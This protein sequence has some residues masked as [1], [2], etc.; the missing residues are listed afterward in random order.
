[1]AQ[2]ASSASSTTSAAL[3]RKST[4]LQRLRR[5]LEELQRCPLVGVAAQPLEENLQE[6]H[7]NMAP[8]KG[9][10][11]GLLLHLVLKFPDD[12][13]SNPPKV[14]LCTQIPHSNVIPNLRGERNFICIDMLKN[15]FWMGGEDDSRPYEG[16]STAYSVSSILLQIQCF[17]FDDWA[18]NYDGR[19]KN[20][21]WDAVIEEGGLRRSADQVRRRLQRAQE[22]AAAFSCSCGHRGSK[23]WP[24]LETPLQRVPGVHLVG[25]VVATVLGVSTT[26]IAVHADGHF[27]LAVNGEASRRAGATHQLQRVSFNNLISSSCLSPPWTQQPESKHVVPATRSAKALAGEQVQYKEEYT[28]YDGSTV[29]AES[30]A[31]GQTSTSSRSSIF[32]GQVGRVVA[33]RLRWHELHVGLEVS[34]RVVAEKDFGLFLDFGAPVNG[35]LPKRAVP[36]ELEMATGSCL[37]AFITSIDHAKWQVRLGLR[38][39]LSR[40]DLEMLLAG[41]SEVV[42]LVVGVQPYGLF[43]D[44]GAP[45]PGLVHSSRVS[46]AVALCSPKVG[47]EIS[48]FISE[49]EPRLQLAVREP[50]FVPPVVVRC[51]ARQVLLLGDNGLPLGSCFMALPRPILAQV[52]HFANLADLAAL[53]GTARGLRAQSDEAASVFWDMQALRCFHT[54]ASFNDEGCVLGVGISLLEEDGRKHLTCDF[55]PISQMAFQELGVRKGVWRNQIAYWLPLAVDS[56]HFARASPALETALGFLGTGRVAEETRSHG[57]RV[58]KPEPEAQHIDI[59]TWLQ[60]RARASE[61]ANQKFRAFLAGEL[62]APSSQKQK[63]PAPKEAKKPLTFC[64]AVVLSV[65]PKLMNSQVVLLMKGE[66]WASQKALSG[67]M[68]FHHLLLAICRAAPA[69]QQEV[70]ERIGS[71][72]SCDAQRVKSEVPNLG[73]FICLLSASNKYGWYLVASPLLGEVFDRNVLWLLKGRPHLGE[74]SKEQ[75]VSEE[76]L[77][78]SFQAAVVSM[79]LV[80]FNVWFLNNVAKAPH[81][82]VDSGASSSSDC[83]AAASCALARYERTKGLPPRSQIEAL[84]RTVKRICEVASWREYF[85]AVCVEHVEP[86]ELCDWLRR[87]VLASLRK[88]YHR[89]GGVHKKRVASAA[90]FRDEYEQLAESYD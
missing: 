19:Y 90:E 18:Q 68:A 67:Y 1:M 63:P 83:C 16:W 43:V 50:P 17:L 7:A 82:H 71:F 49:L 44:V 13:P 37:R 66:V 40:T 47:D 32:S 14:Q 79:R 78:C 6:W 28:S 70:E 52:L 54:R 85:Q 60:R 36:R 8:D 39:V 86:S 84:H 74:V 72:L 41:S 80:M 35:L 38:K 76:R 53:G 29:E 12:Y 46:A 21:L 25:D 42:G 4:A 48:V 45:R 73:E 15:F 33:K 87:S 30:L 88:G 20:T 10:F 55:D 31:E 51:P 5:D 2:M 58:R 69:V 61:K 64:P 27:D 23:P 62:A 89:P 22:D 77:R 3:R 75:G 34:G 81:V 11:A 24:P 56:R 59:E 65:L 26:V 9:N 57:P